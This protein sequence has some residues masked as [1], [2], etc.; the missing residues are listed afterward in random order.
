M[1]QKN[2]AHGERERGREMERDRE[3]GGGQ[4]GGRERRQ[5]TKE[6]LALVESE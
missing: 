3:E 2:R 5:M 6:M 1:V 4:E